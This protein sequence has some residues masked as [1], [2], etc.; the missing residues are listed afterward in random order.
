LR[1]SISANKYGGKSLILLAFLMAMLNLTRPPDMKLSRL[2]LFFAILTTA[3]EMDGSLTN[4]R[5]FPHVRLHEKAKLY[6]WRVIRRFLL[7][8]FSLNHCIPLA[9]FSALLKHHGHGCHYRRL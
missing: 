8:N 7:Q 4:S 1:R 3:T 6:S 9:K 2:Y 5:E